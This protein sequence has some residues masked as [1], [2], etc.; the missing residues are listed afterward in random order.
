MA[1]EKMWAG[2][3]SKSLSQVADDFNSSIHFDCKMFKQDI[4][5]SMAHAYMLGQQGII[6]KS[7]SEAIIKTLEEILADLIK[8]GYKGFACLEPHLGS[9]DGLAGLELDDKMTKLEKSDE[10]KFTLAYNSLCKI[11]DEVGA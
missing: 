7:D 1:N 2:R 4:T 5:G 6:S 3:F 9:F 8:N 10:S 11:L